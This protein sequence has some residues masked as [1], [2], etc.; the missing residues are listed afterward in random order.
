SFSS[1]IFLTEFL[2]VGLCDAPPRLPSAELKKLYRGITVF[3]YNSMVEYVCRPGYMRNVN[4]QGILVC[5][6]NNQWHG[7]R[8]FCI[9]KLCPYPTEPANGRLVLGESFIF[10]STVNFTCN[11]GYRLVGDSEIRCVIKN[12]VLTWDRDIPICDPI[13]CTPPPEIANGEHSGAG[14]DLFEFGASVTYWCHTVRRGERPFSLV[15]DASIFCTTTDNVNGVW[16]KPAPECRVVSCEHPRV[17]NG[18]LL[19]GYRA[20]YGYRD[21]AVFDCNFR[22][23]INGSDASTCGENGLWDPPLPLCQLSSCDDPPDVRNAVKAKLA[24]NLFPVET[25]ITYECREGH[26]FSLGETTRHIKCLPNFTWSETPDACERIRCQRPDINNG[27]PL[28][29]YEDKDDYMYGD[30]LEITCNDGF[31]FKGRG[32]NVVLRCASDGTWDPE[33]PECTEVVR[34]PKPTVER[35]RVTPQ[36]VTFPYGTA[37]RFSCEEGFALQGDAESQCL[38]D[39]TW[40]PP[41]PSCRPGGYQTQADAPRPVCRSRGCCFFH[42]EQVEFAGHVLLCVL[43]LHYFLSHIF[44]PV[45]CSQPLR[46]EDLVIYSPRLWYGVNETLL[47]YCRQG[48]RQSASSK[49]TC[50]ANGTWIPQPTCK[51]RDTCEKILRKRETFQCGVPLTELKTLLEVQKLYLEIQKLEK[52]L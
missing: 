37:V 45:Q 30:R 35:G 42:Q 6:G 39:G 20:E 31:A 49:S 50:S 12:G 9:P 19:S 33:I 4:S 15:G 34:C 47:F 28:N 23:T 2:S 16:S 41:P 44:L 14:K 32:S 21:T 24:G 26:Q 46:G 7:S 29:I 43:P 36:R 38:A 1:S 25:I 22:Y 13:P 8:D 17:E 11:T 10:G 52:E 48:G 51:K 18:Q 5:G 3:P 40:D 27:K